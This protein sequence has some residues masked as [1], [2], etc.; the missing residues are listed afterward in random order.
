V[1]IPDT[2]TVESTIE[3]DRSGMAPADLLVSVDIDHTYRGDLV[4]DLIA[5][6]GSTANLKQSDGWDSAD[7]VVETWTVD[8]SS[9]AASGTWRLRVQDVYSGDTG[10]IRSWSLE[11]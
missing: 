2:S 5:P 6:D 4:I 3:V 8:A 9:V 10:T 11:F 7:D 1:A